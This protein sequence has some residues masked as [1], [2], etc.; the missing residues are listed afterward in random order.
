[1]SSVLRTPGR[2][3][4]SMAESSFD[5]WIKHYRQDENSPNAG[6]S[7]YAKGS[8]VALALDLSLRFVGRVSLDDL[9]RALWIRHGHPGIGVPEDAIEKLASELAGVDLGDFFTRYVFGTEDVP[10]ARLLEEFGVTLHFRAATGPKDRGG[11][12]AQ[13]EAPG[14]MLGARVGPDLKLTYVVRGGPASRA[15]LSA[16]DTLVAIDGIK[17]SAEL[18]AAHLKGPRGAG[19]LAILAFRRDELRSFELELQP[20]PLDTAWLALAADA[21]PSAIARRDAWLGTPG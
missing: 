6:I 4:Q 17:A 7:Y 13:S 2:L 9:M 21:G 18:L 11:K 8:L 14:K 16:G 3:T 10:L 12:P 20:P 1:L 19:P 5:A 15:G